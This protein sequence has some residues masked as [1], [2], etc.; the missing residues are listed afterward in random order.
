MPFLIHE[1]HKIDLY[2]NHFWLNRKYDFVYGIASSSLIDIVDK[3]IVYVCL[4]PPIVIHDNLN[5][6]RTFAEKDKQIKHIQKPK[7]PIKQW[8]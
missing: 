2:I 1:I 7:N 6:L 3:W 4:Y 8:L 5:S